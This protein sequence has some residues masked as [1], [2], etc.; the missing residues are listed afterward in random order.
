[1]LAT[2]VPVLLLLPW[3]SSAPVD[4]GATDGGGFRASSDN[5]QQQQ[6]HKDQEPIV[7]MLHQTISSIAEELKTLKSVVADHSAALVAVEERL[8]D[9]GSR[10]HPRDDNNNQDD[11]SLHNLRKLQRD[12][13]ADPISREATN[14]FAEV[15][16]SAWF[17]LGGQVE[18]EPTTDP[19]HHRAQDSEGC[20]ALVDEVNFRCCGEQDENCCVNTATGTPVAYNVDCAAVFLPFWAGCAANFQLSDDDLLALQRT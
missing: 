20:A 16:D 14:Y 2:M 19:G 17:D 6:Q 3:V 12:G 10:T 11:H 4:G 1:M 18:P 9:V 15:N 8:R 5:Q 7:A 13:D